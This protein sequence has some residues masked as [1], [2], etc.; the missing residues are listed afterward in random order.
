[1]GIPSEIL[2][3]PG[4]LTAIEYQL[5]QTHAQVGYDILTHGIAT[6]PWPI[7][8]IVHQHHERMDGSGYPLGLKGADLLLES[9]ILAVADVMEAMASHR[10]YRAALGIE[11][12]LAEISTH[13]GRL[14]DAD[15]VGSC[16][17]LFAD[18]RFSF[19]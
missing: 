8:T 13:Q 11:S 4:K 17:S 18:G 1:M 19:E 5:I 2:S 12:A 14:Y 15:V 3:K 7:K 9:R 6:F 10:P 16:L